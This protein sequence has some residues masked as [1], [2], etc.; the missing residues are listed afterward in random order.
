MSFDVNHFLAI[1]NT[2]D[3]P[4]NSVLGDSLKGS[5]SQ[6]IFPSLRKFEINAFCSRK[7]KI[8]ALMPSELGGGDFS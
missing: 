7:N 5:L 6:R 8:M 3:K 4:M 2:T 1:N